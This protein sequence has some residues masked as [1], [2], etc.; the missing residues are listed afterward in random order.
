[1][2]KAGTSGSTSPCHRAHGC[3]SPTF[4]LLH[5]VSFHLFCFS[6]DA[7]LLV[8]ALNPYCWCMMQHDAAHTSQAILALCIKGISQQVVVWSM[9][10]RCSLWSRTTCPLQWPGGSPRSELNPCRLLQCSRHREM[11]KT[12]QKAYF[13]T[14][15]ALKQQ[16]KS[17]SQQLQSKCMIAP[18]INW[19]KKSWSRSS[20]LPE[21]LPAQLSDDYK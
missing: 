19:R 2:R 15:P 4:T 9:Q 10:W 1:M 14:F 7:E 3:V 5:H 16:L 17:S 20:E 18:P 12:G 11:H 8:L 6:G 13:T 21:V